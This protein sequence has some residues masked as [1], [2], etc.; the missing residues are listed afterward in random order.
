MNRDG[1]FNVER[2]GL[3]WWDYVNPYHKLLTISWPW[4]L[5]VVLAGYT[6]TNCVFAVAYVACGPGALGGSAASAV[7]GRF[8][9]AFFFSVQ[10]LATIGYGKL[11]PEGGLANVVVAVEALA[12]LLGFAVATGLLYA[13]VSRPTA[14]IMFSDCAVIAPYQGRTGLMFRA[15]NGRSNELT[16]VQAAVTLSRL[17]GPARTRKFLL[18]TLERTRVT[19]L[20]TQW[21]VV[22][23]IDEASPLWGMN[24]RE[25]RESGPELL[26]LMTAMDE[27][28]SQM[29]HI[30]SSYRGEEFVWGA[31]FRD[32][33]ARSPEGR[34]TFDVTRLGEID[35][36]E[37]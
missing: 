25:F 30:R 1:T 31:K 28:F 8:V 32:V 36:M 3:P 29:V 23:P 33:L 21:V 16:E 10:T 22:H 7:G 24:E 35:R 4:F 37:L 6:I 12:G 14:K 19:F 27:T 34:I 18:L 2:T 26:I 15:A 20:A 17:E 5:A 9:D 11:T 13:R